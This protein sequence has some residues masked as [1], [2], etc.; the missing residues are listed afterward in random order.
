M[1]NILVLVIA[2]LYWRLAVGEHE[3]G[4]LIDLEKASSISRG[5]RVV[6]PPGMSSVYLFA[7]YLV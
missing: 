1:S 2:I 3:E 5:Q 6:T 4:T 7:I